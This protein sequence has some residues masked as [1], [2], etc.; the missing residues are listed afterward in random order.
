[1]PT[2][3][4]SQTAASSGYEQ[5]FGF[6]EPPFSLAVNTRFR[7]ESVSH[8]AALA[9]VSYA[10][11]RREPIVVVTGEIG[12]GKTLL[13]RTVVESLPRRTFLSVIDDPM[14]ERDDLLKR[15]LEDFG[16]ISSAGAVVVQATRHELVHAL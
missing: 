9:Q 6:S 15:I 3:S 1:M 7:F 16:V 13:C 12:M 4:I 8:R 10:L 5:F 11:E 14:L 2:V